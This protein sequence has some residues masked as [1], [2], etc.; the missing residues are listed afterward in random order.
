MTK[1]FG[2]VAAVDNL[3][4]Q[5]PRGSIVSLLGPSGCGKTTTLRMIAG[6]E[7]PDEGTVLIGG[8]DMRGK[9]PYERTVGL[10]FQDYAL[11]PHMSV[12]DN[13]AYGLRRRGAD[14]REIPARIREMLRLVKLGGLEKRQP[15]TLSGGQQQR[16]ALARALATTPTV[17]LLDEPLSALDAKLR[18]ELRMELKEIIGSVGTST[19]VVTH[20]QEEAL[21]LGERVI[22]MNEG[23]LEQEGTPEEIYG[24]PKSKFVAEFIGRSNWFRVTLGEAVGEGIWQCH[25]KHDLRLQVRAENPSEGLSYDIGVRPERLRIIVDGVN[26]SVDDDNVNRLMGVVRKGM[27]LGDDIETAVQLFNGQLVTAVEKN[28]GQAPHTEGSKVTLMFRP[29]DC[30]VIPLSPS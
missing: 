30:L 11:F 24:R 20:D 22:V 8:A 15:A 10:V 1:R 5:V 29:D 7:T 18:L 9:R 26:K 4:L 19:I 17:L 28:L 13:I 3:S 27:H 23:R 14:R 16:V 2:N 21:S 6:F 12:E 25:G